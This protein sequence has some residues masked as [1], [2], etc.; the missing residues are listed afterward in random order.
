MLLHPILHDL[1]A[2]ANF[3]EMAVHPFNHGSVRVSQLFRNRVNA[4]RPSL[5]ERLQPRARVR[6]TKRLRPNLAHLRAPALRALHEVELTGVCRDAI[7]EGADLIQYRLSSHSARRRWK[8]DTSWR[9]VRAEDV[10]P[11]NLF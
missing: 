4:D 2:V 9:S 5:I 10:G 3:T 7:D 8:Q 6:M 1:G 11:E